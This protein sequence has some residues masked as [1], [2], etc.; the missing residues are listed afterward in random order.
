MMPIIIN[1]LLDLEQKLSKLKNEFNNRNKKYDELIIKIH[2][3]K[4]D[5]QLNDA[6]NM[7]L[8]TSVGDILQKNINNNTIDNIIN[9]IRLKPN[10]SQNINDL[11]N[12]NDFKYI[13][14]SLVPDPTID[15]NVG[16]MNEYVDDLKNFKSLYVN[17]KELIDY[18]KLLNIIAVND[19]INDVKKSIPSKYETLIPLLHDKRNTINKNYIKAFLDEH[20]I[21]SFNIIKDIVGHEDVSMSERY[22]DNPKEDGFLKYFS[23]EGI[24]KIEEK[25]LS[26]LN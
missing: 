15:P 1:E 21:D 14:D 5:P 3:L 25:K 11:S 18:I 7:I 9:E 10:A 17:D 24:N 2:D 19:D 23:D 22:D 16:E 4:N 12:S 26:D 13:M 20:I 8:T 6:I